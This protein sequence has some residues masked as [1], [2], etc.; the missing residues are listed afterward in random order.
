MTRGVRRYLQL[1]GER[2]EERLAEQRSLLLS[3]EPILASGSP[4]RSGIDEF[5]GVEGSDLQEAM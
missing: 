4:H 5:P 1:H 3:V 2:L